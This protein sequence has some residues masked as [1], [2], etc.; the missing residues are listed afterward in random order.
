MQTPVS[1]EGMRLR[2]KGIIKT[3]PKGSQYFQFLLKTGE[4]PRWQKRQEQQP[5]VLVLT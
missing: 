5:F 1:Q 4:K 2:P 3:D